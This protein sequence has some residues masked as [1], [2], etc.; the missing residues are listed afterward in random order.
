MK[1]ANS[2]FTLCICFVLGMLTSVDSNSQPC[3]ELMSD[4]NTIAASNDYFSALE[5]YEKA[6][7]CFLTEAKYPEYITA[8]AYVLDCLDKTLQ[9]GRLDSDLSRF[10]SEIERIKGDLPPGKYES[11]NLT[12]L[13]FRA[14]LLNKRG[15]SDGAIALFTHA[16][17]SIRAIPEQ[18]RTADDE[19][20]E[21]KLLLFLAKQYE[22]RGGFSQ[23]I[24]VAN[25][26]L[27]VAL[28]DADRYLT[29]GVIIPVYEI[30][31]RCNTRL[32]NI[33]L[34]IRY[35]RTINSQL[36]AVS[37]RNTERRIT[38]LL[39][40]S[41][42]HL[43]NNA[44]DSARTY[45][46]QAEQLQ[47]DGQT[48]FEIVSQKGHVNFADLDYPAALASFNEARQ[49]AAGLGDTYNNMVAS[50]DLMIGKLEIFSGDYQ[51]GVKTLHNALTHLTYEFDNTNV[52]TNPSAEDLFVQR[53]IVQIIN[54]KAQGLGL[55]Y[56]HGIGDSTDLDAAWR[57]VSLGLEY[58][59]NLRTS[60][61]TEN[62]KALI[63]EESYPLFSTAL[64]ICHDFVINS[65][66]NDWVDSAFTVIE[67]SKALNLLDAVIHEQAKDFAGIPDSLIQQEAFLRNQITSTEKLL[68]D[69]QE[70][71]DPNDSL[72]VRLTAERREFTS[73]YRSLIGTYEENYPDYHAL[74][75]GVEVPALTDAMKALR[76]DEQLIEYFIAGSAMY[77]LQ[78]SSTQRKL[79]RLPSHRSDIDAKVNVYQDALEDYQ[80]TKSSE[81][82]TE[83]F[84][85]ASELYNILLGS[86][87]DLKPRLIIIPDGKVGAV[88]FAGLV[89]SDSDSPSDLRTAPYLVW[90]HEFTYAY[91][92]SLY[93]QLNDRETGMYSGS[94]SFAPESLEL[95]LQ[96]S[97]E[98]SRQVSKMLNAKTLTGEKCTASRVREHMED[99]DFQIVHFATHGYAD[100]GDSRESYL[101]LSG[102][103]EESR[104][105]AGELYSMSLN[106][107]LIYLSACET[108]RGRS[109]RGE[110]I[111]SLARAFFYAGADALVTTLWP[112][113][114]KR[115]MELTVRF[116]DFLKSGSHPALAV[117]EAQRDYLKSVSSEDR[118]YAH[119]VY[120]SGYVA[121]GSNTL[122]YTPSRRVGPL[123]ASM[124]FLAFL[125][126]AWNFFRKKLRKG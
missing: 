123:L 72:I 23:A 114:D 11:M 47:S 126:L 50:C 32:G 88:S 116:F 100:Y 38:T 53:E 66:N 24:E 29:D 49:I 17:D 21:F 18:Q 42:L 95:N 77:A 122:A 56:V 113:D 108:G 107:G 96:Y 85:V 94:I 78:A 31:A 28:A 90:D 27:E 67:K 106:A 1:P 46:E 93:E 68:A 62:D 101:S 102:S 125:L 10:E 76:E 16:L 26:A 92:Y 51:R 20:R 3:G 98:E 109:V 112:V 13:Q 15:N 75:Y 60:Y 43:R 2:A 124:A 57:T 81:A 39:A 104:L 103:G 120:W 22:A 70:S 91:S 40:L 7:D 65:N 73:R 52:H 82:S 83:Y 33:D 30:L 110:G 111:M 48:R 58:L 9:A 45:C 74:K 4:A 25:N 71:R 69:L 6:R 84:A 97:K 34:A 89:S 115:S 80:N 5:Q 54:F 19:T 119:P 59:D 12:A 35:L 8:W 41:D 105:N 86:L 61:L 64:S 121:S 79:S 99:Q 55:Q 14:L 87:D 36:P 117:A 63:I 37:L 118:I 44:T